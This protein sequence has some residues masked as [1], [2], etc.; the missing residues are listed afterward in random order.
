MEDDFRVITGY[1]M[2]F[3]GA[4]HRSVRNVNDGPALVS[5]SADFNGAAHRSVRNAPCCQ[6]SPIWR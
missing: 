4:A 2:D 6:S 1:L 5:V 3:N